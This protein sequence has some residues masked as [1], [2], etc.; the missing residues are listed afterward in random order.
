MYLHEETEIYVLPVCGITGGS[1]IDFLALP[2]NKKTF[3]FE[4]LGRAKT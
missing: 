4:H 1:G 3:F 2:P